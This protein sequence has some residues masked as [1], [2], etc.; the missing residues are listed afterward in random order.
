M[1]DKSAI[2]NWFLTGKKPT[3]AQYWA[4]WDSFWH[5]DETIPQ[6]S[7]QN[8][9]Q[10]LNAKAEKSQFDAHKTDPDAHSELVGRAKFITVGELLIFKH[11]TNN[12]PAKKYTL[13]KND[14]VQG[15]VDG[16]WITAYYNGGEKSALINYSIITNA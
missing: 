13:E 3:E 2:R 10:T 11:P 4:T 14:L 7:V 15:F 6:S 8:L 12:D 9:I 1:A 16:T 5:K